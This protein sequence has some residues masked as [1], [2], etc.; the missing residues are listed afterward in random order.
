VSPFF[1]QS[2]AYVDAVIGFVH[3]WFAVDIW[4]IQN[5]L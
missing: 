4:R 3:R 1:C 2:G 5:A